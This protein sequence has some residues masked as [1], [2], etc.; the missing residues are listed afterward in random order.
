MAQRARILG[1]SWIA[2]LALVPGLSKPCLAEAP[3]SGAFQLVF[4]TR[5]QAMHFTRDSSVLVKQGRAESLQATEPGVDLGLYRG[6]VL[7][8][9]P[10]TDPA[11]GRYRVRETLRTPLG[12]LTWT[13]V[14]VVLDSGSASD[15]ALGWSRGRITGGTGL[16][17]R[18]RGTVDCPSSAVGDTGGLRT[19]GHADAPAPA[20][21][22]VGAW[23]MLPGIRRANPPKPETQRAARERP[24]AARFVGSGGAL[25]PSVAPYTGS[26][27]L[28]VVGQFPG[29]AA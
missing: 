10:D 27:L 20:R 6:R 18:A 15:E 11:S 16:F 23:P 9:D 26:L 3:E 2:A 25:R 8:S 1:A 7:L 21:D 14:L 5:L 24:L 19:P 13:A 12:S 29:R 17:A 28:P 22:V 4:V